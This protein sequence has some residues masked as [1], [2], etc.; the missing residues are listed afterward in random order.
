M[1]VKHSLRWL[2]KSDNPL[3]LEARNA[4]SGTEDCALCCM[5]FEIDY[6][7]SDGNTSKC[8]FEEIFEDELEHFQQMADFY[9]VPVDIVALEYLPNESKEVVQFD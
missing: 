1:R 5:F 6:T 7:D 9:K 3:A 8:E 4:F 2:A